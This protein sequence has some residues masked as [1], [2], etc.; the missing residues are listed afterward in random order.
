M[1]IIKGIPRIN[2]SY[3]IIEEF[4]EFKN[5]VKELDVKFVYF[6]KGNHSSPTV[7]TDSTSI[8]TMV[9]KRKMPFTNQS[10]ANDTQIYFDGD[11]FGFYIMVLGFFVIVMDFLILMNMIKLSVLVAIANKSIIKF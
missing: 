5:M 6:F 3:V 2:T 7:S 4:D 11:C 10:S 8:R 9:V 1:K